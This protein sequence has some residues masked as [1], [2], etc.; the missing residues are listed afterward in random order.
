MAD[1][2]FREDFTRK[3]KDKNYDNSEENKLREN[4]ICKVK[5]VCDHF[6]ISDDTFFRTI[7]LYDFQE[8]VIIDS[9]V[10]RHETMKEWLDEI[11]KFGEASD[12]EERHQQYLKF[13]EVITCFMVAMK[14]YDFELETPTLRDILKYFKIGKMNFSNKEDSLDKKKIKE[15]QAIVFETVYEYIWERQIDLLF[16]IDWKLPIINIKHFS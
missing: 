12:N 13:F 16:R 10:I 6:K 8:R 11:F 1:M 15:I 5:K 4:L 9:S 2:E 3:L 7:F 14:Y